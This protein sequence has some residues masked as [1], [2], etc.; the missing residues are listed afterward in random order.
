MIIERDYTVINEDDL[1]IILNKAKE[2]IERFFLSKNGEK[3]RVLYNYKKPILVALCQDA[4]MHFYDRVNGIKDFDVWFFYPFNKKDL[5]Y[6]TRWECDFEYPKFGQHPDMLKYK[7]RKI[8]VMVRTIKT[9][10]VDPVEI[11][12]DYLKMGK[13]KTAEHLSKKAVVL[14]EPERYFAKVIWYKG[15]LKL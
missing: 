7:G 1:K 4:A 8:D 2:R 10:K 15:I 5:P 6:R 3:W 14:L 11:I 13:T 12:I 9:D